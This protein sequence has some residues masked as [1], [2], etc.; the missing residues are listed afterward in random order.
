MKFWKCLFHFF[1]KTVCAPVKKIRTVS[2]G[3]RVRN[4]WSHKH[5]ERVSRS[6]DVAEH[7]EYS[8]KV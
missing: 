1:R 2:I 4:A 7:D 5:N 3:I 8:E 6:I